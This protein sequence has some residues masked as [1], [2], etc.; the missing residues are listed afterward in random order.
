MR[1]TST[2]LKA[3]LF[4]TAAG[5]LARPASAQTTRTST[6]NANSIILIDVA[7]LHHSPLGQAREWAA[8]HL[9]EYAVGRTPFPPTA[10]SIMF[11]RE[12]DPAGFHTVRREV[13][14]V[15]TVAPIGF[16]RLT[17]VV[18][19]KVQKIGDRNVVASPRG[20]LAALLDDK[21]AAAFYPADR[22]AFARWLKDIPQFEHGKVS[23]YLT[24]VTASWP[25]GGQIVMALDLS[26]SSDESTIFQELRIQKDLVKTDEQARALAHAFARLEGMRLAINVTD[27]I[28]AEW[29]VEFS[30]P[31][32]ASQQ[33]LRL[34]LADAV[35][36]MTDPSFDL[37]KWTMT[38][39]SLQVV[40]KSTLT[41]EQLRGVFDS[42]HS[43]ILTGQTFSP[44]GAPNLN[45][46]EAS[47]RYFRQVNNVVNALDRFAD[48]LSDY[49][50]A[51]NEYDRSAARIQRLSTANVD[52]EVLRYGD[53]VAKTL[54]GISSALRGVP[55][56]AA[57]QTATVWDD[58]F[59]RG[60]AFFNPGWTYPWRWGVLP[61]VFV[62]QPSPVGVARGNVARYM[63]DEETQRRNEWL[64]IRELTRATDSKM[65]N[66]YG[67]D[68][69][70]KK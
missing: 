41:P 48:Q 29:V 65:A 26:G 38:T 10:Q 67:V 17:E 70:P 53:A 31:F 52:A 35:K 24:R 64:K 15:H 51:A 14:I 46:L 56:E 5:L 36:R 57:V 11:A 54:F 20:F 37:A 69:I 61:P 16:Q 25:K 3:I 66:K 12:I 32:T 22:Q 49:I 1:V 55:R 62:N 45:Q 2:M 43:P 21:S 9:E 68:F 40:F 34:F 27:K 23:P 30:E 8:R 50:L 47:Q 28:E 63:A 7:G 6:S 44:T 59:F 19:G 60:P 13:A 33:T 39:T 58:R 4:V 42:I 18:G